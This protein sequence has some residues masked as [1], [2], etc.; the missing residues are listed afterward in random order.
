MNEAF[1]GL[2]RKFILLFFDDTLIYSNDWDIHKEFEMTPIPNFL[3]VVVMCN[4]N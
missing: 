3:K 2:L 4:L 1:K